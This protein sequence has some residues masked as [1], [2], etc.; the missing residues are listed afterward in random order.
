MRGLEDRHWWFVSRRR[1]AGQMLDSL[2][3]P[4]L[5]RILDTG[6]VIEAKVLCLGSPFETYQETSFY[7]H[8]INKLSQALQ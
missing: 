3:L 6:C 2:D 5:S 4:K 8:I 1:I 7:I